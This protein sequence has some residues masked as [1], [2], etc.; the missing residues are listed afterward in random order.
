[1]QKLN[2]LK[3][4]DEAIIQSVKAKQNIKKRFLDIGLVKGTKIKVLLISPLKDMTAYL[5]KG[6]VIA[7]RKEDTKDIIVKVIK[8]KL[9]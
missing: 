2:D 6:A 5:I 4:N 9:V 1:M 8:W 3:I 7:I